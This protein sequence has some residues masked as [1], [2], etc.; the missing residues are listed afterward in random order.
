MTVK[1]SNQLRRNAIRVSQ[2]FDFMSTSQPLHQKDGPAKPQ[3]RRLRGRG[4][5]CLLSLGP[6]TPLDRVW[7]G[8]IVPRF[9]CLLGLYLF[10]EV[11][12]PEMGFA[13]HKFIQL[14]T[15]RVPVGHESCL[16]LYE[17][18]VGITISGFST[19]WKRHSQQF[20]NEKLIIQTI[21]LLFILTIFFN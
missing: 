21:F 13:N 3:P 7:L 19:F 20:A 6:K 2:S 16:K 4:N 14:W 12:K 11:E 8:S 5:L 1:Q 18:V 15:G 9:L 17:R 10:Q